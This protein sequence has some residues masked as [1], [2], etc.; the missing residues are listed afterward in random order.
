[1]GSRSI[2]A[3]SAQSAPSEVLE[4]FQLEDGAA[5]RVLSVGRPLDPTTRKALLGAG[6]ELNEVPTVADALREMLTSLYDVVVVRASV[7]RNLDGLRFVRELK[8]RESAAGFI[9]LRGLRYIY[10]VVP[11]V[12]PPLEG[13]SE[14]AVFEA[15]DLWYLADTTQVPL[16]EAILRVT[17]SA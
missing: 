11:F 1:M 7:M 2:L 10:D 9:D 5:R 15:R 14:Y 16:D 4:E 12:V 17:R 8:N 6:C 3:P 13:T